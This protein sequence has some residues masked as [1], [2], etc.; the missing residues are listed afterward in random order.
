MQN[1]NTYII[2]VDVAA[3]DLY[4]YG[5]VYCIPDNKC[6]MSVVVSL[7]QAMPVVVSLLVISWMF[8]STAG[9]CPYGYKCHLERNTYVLECDLFDK[10]QQLKVDDVPAIATHLKIICTYRRPSLTLT[11][12]NLPNIQK[13]TLDHLDLAT[14]DDTMFRGVTNMSHLVLKKLSRKR[15]DNDSFSGLRNL[16]SLEIEHLDE[17]KYMHPNMLT[18]LL[19]LQSLSFR[20]VGSVYDALNYTDYGLVIQGINSRRPF[21]TLVLYA[22]HSPQHHETSLVMTDL[23]RNG[24]ACSYSVRHLD[25]GRN[26]I[27]YIWG[28]LV[29]TLPLLEYLS[30]NENAILGS[31]GVDK[32][33]I[34]WGTLFYHPSLKTIDIIGMNPTTEVSKDVWF[35]LDAEENCR[36]AINVTMGEH[37][38]AANFANSTF[39]PNSLVQQ[40]FHFCL[41]DPHN[42]F[43]YID[44]SNM[45]CTKSSIGS[46]TDIRSL[47]YM[48]VQNYSFRGIPVNLFHNLSNLTM[49]LLGKNDIGNIIANDT[50]NRIFRNNNK[51]VT[52][53]LAAC[54][55]THIPPSEF[56]NQR[57]LRHLNLSEN[58]L[59][60]FD[61]ELHHLKHLRHL[62]LS[63]NQ[64]STLSVSARKALDEIPTVEVDISGNP[65]LCD[66][67]NT[68]F[69]TWIH[70]TKRKFLNKQHTQ[71]TGKNHTPNLLFYFDHE[72]L[73][74]SC[75][76][77]N[78]RWYLTILLPI[79]IA[80]II[81][82][83][84]ICAL[85]RYRWKCAYCCS[86]IHVY[87]MSSGDKVDPVVYE[88]DAFI[89]Y[90][91]SDRAWVCSELLKRLEDGH[92]STIIHQRDF[93]PGSVLHDSIIESIDKCRYTILVFS[94]DFLASD[95]CKLETHLARSCIITQGRDVIVPI[96]LREFPNATLSPT[97][98]GILEKSYLKWS[99][100]S[101]EQPE[102]WD[103]LI[104]KLTHGG[105]IRP[106]DM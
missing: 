87:K 24:S 7:P 56:N 79:G 21:H 65:L 64:L 4:I 26:S 101:D 6:R 63:H 100:N 76:S 66:C 62:D 84:L 93:L 52:L 1:Y 48:N 80:F 91:S 45:R 68:D 33:S 47:E 75:R 99:D 95:W 54:H 102:F 35:D 32:F 51:L 40:A 53:D 94:P 15:F 3:F 18:P 97:F 50:A 17:L 23:I 106:L 70:T 78:T 77:P 92:V 19:S 90:S 86:R 11:L 44:A 98:Q 85:Y 28:S 73:M 10:T 69:V 83:V 59:R 58:A 43:K 89:C 22:I 37:L 12:A 103:R 71:C 13:L 16:R 41:K 57:Q 49:L 2:V 60:R 81:I 46:L 55:L 39:Y 25:I 82:A 30:L 74:D 36:M 38:H 5:D 34:F 9:S 104:T 88:R 29:T 14:W 72:A 61:V 8:Q 105:N 20:H 31:R 67:S 42:A 27:N 96:V